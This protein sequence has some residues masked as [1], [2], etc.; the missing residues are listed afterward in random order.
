MSH[1]LGDV[2]DAF[3]LSF[4]NLI[5]FQDIAVTATTAV[6]CP[7]IATAQHWPLPAFPHRTYAVTCGLRI[8]DMQD[9]WVHK[10][11]A[12]RVNKCMAWRTHAR[13]SSWRHMRGVTFCMHIGPA[14]AHCGYMFVQVRVHAPR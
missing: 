14:Q 11:S 8:L 6:A 10:P 1:G 12:R 4:P 13:V 5:L 9:L 7:Q 3:T 2:K